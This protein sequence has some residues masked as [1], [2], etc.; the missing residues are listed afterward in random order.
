MLSRRRFVRLDPNP[1]NNRPGWLNSHIAD[2]ARLIKYGIVGCI[3]IAVNLGVLALLIKTFSL[4]GWIPSAAAN[5][6]STV[7][8]FIL[9]NLWTFS[10]RQ[11]RGIHL[12]RGFVAFTL[13]S[14]AGIC[15]STAAYVGFTR[16]AAHLALANARSGGLKIA[17]VCQFAAVLLGAAVS[18]VLNREFTWPHKHKHAAANS[19]QTQES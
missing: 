8:N 15:V 19:T 4:R 10:D 3:G 5:V 13:T 14:I 12:V 17:L 11:H 18:Y 7:G 6:A 1:G 16:I 9:H 2:K